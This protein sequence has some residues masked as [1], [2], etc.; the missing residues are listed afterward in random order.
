MKEN[1]CSPP[2]GGKISLSKESRM[3]F[4]S[5]AFAAM[6]TAEKGDLDFILAFARESECPG[7]WEILAE[8]A[9]ESFS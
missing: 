3:W 7:V 9:K 1:C 6:D 8:V 4:V 5:L 2:G